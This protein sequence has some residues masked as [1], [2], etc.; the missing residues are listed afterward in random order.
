MNN[1]VRGWWQQRVEVPRLLAL[2][3]RCDGATALEIGGGQGLG[4]QLIQQKF[5][6]D[7]VLSI[8]LDMTMCRRALRRTASQGQRHIAQADC[9]QLPL[10][11]AQFDALFDFGVL[12]HVPNWQS[13]AA[14]ITRVARTGAQLYTMEM[15]RDFIQHPIWKRVLT[16]PQT[17][18]FDHQEFIACW[19]Q[20]GWRLTGQHRLTQGMGWSTFVKT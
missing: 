8:D 13:A 7:Q 10:A 20:L 15:Y 4:A 19:Q 16:H 5:G 6:A 3:G 14:E 18:R 12:H 17:N 9:T 1:P 11:D 2:G